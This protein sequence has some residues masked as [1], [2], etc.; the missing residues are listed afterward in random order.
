MRAPRD[1][2]QGPDLVWEDLAGSAAQD[3][4]F[5]SEAGSTSAPARAAET[6]AQSLARTQRDVQLQLSQQVLR[7]HQAIQRKQ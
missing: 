1:A 2:D 3:P 7:V 5:G 6:F 4:V